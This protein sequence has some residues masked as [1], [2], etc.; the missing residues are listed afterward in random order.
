M[1]LL[2]DF[3]NKTVLV[4]TYGQ[5][6]EGILAYFTKGDAADHIPINLIL[7]GECGLIIVRNWNLVKR[8]NFEG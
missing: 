6:I 3:I 4:E 5:Q 1:D 2:Q 8:A 7:K